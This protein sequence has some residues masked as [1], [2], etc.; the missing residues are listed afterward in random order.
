MAFGKKSTSGSPPPP[1]PA[2]DPASAQ[3][4]NKKDEPAKKERSAPATGDQL[5]HL[6]AL[7]KEGTDK[8]PRKSMSDDVILTHEGGDGEK[9]PQD[10]MTSLRLQRARNRIW[11]DLRDGIDLKALARMD[12]KDRKSVV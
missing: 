4:Q 10:N 2:A 1:K 6:Q 3:Q 5:A 11:L 8:K 9:S 12:G 7:S